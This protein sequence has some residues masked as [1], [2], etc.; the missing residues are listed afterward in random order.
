MSKIPEWKRQ[1]VAMF[2]FGADE[3]VVANI[4]KRLSVMTIGAKDFT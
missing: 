3:V 4:S 2:S 1:K